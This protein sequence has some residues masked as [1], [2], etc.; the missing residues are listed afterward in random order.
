MIYQI[1]SSICEVY[2]RL[3]FEREKILQTLSKEHGNGY[4][5]DNDKIHCKFLN[6]MSS[7]SCR[8]VIFVPQKWNKSSQIF[9]NVEAYVLEAVC[10]L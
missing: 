2:S 1:S 6:W 9:G 10:K 3:D 5:E 7:P 8:V 4:I